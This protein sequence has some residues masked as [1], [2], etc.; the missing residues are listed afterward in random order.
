[1]T[2]TPDPPARL[3]IPALLAELTLEEKAA[4]LDGSDFWHTEPIARL[5]IPA[6]MVTDGPHGLRKQAVAGDHLGIGTSVPATCFPP[7][8]GLASTWDVDLLARVGVA[9]GDECRAE[10]VAVLLGPGV[11]M[12]RSPLCGRNFEYFS[13][14]PLLAGELGAALVRGIQSRGVGTSLKHFAA[15]NQETERMSVSAEVDERTL[16]EIYLP[17]FERIVTSARP[18]TVM[19]SYNRINGVYASENRWLLTDVLRGDWGY[20]GVVVSDWG[21]VNDRAAAVHAG[22]DLEMPSSGGGGQR[23]ILAAIAAGTLSLPDVDLAVTRVLTLVDRALPAL[24]PGQTFDAAA[25]HALAREAAAASAVLLK[26]DGAILPLDPRVGGAIAVVGEFARTPRYQG[27][28]SSQVVPTRLDDALTAVRQLVGG[29][30]E[31]T[32]APGYVPDAEQGDAALVAQAV[33]HA[34]AAQVVVLFLGLPAADE[35][36]GYDRTHLDLPAAQL[37][38]L[39]AVAAVNDQVVVVLSNGSVVALHPWQDRAR[40]VLEGW[41]LGQGGGQA[42]AD[43]LFGAVN[44]SGRLAETVPVRHCDNPTIGAF[45]G[46]LGSVRYGEGLLIGYRW[47]DAHRLEVSYP[48]GH[49][50]SYTTFGYT[51]LTTTVLCAGPE[52]QVEVGLTVTNTGSRAGRETVQVYVAD[53]ESSVFRPDQELKGFAPVSLEPG[54]SARVTLMLDARAFS[55][56][57][58]QLH[59]WVVEGG[60]FEIRVGASSRDVRLSGTVELTG[61]ALTPPLSPQSPASAWLDHPMTGPALQARFADAS[62]VAAGLFDPS[63]AEMMRAIPLDRLSRFPGFPIAEDELAA[64]ATAANE[65]TAS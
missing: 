29:A 19:C 17:A 64:L 62:N 49:G 59:R 18:W 30:R 10:Q 61:D 16:R 26:N 6:V 55:F 53:P 23:K 8:A 34:Q 7:A 12:K 15:N 46:E 44:P 35:S 47:Y 41:L 2:V 42:V 50:L 20:D 4:L 21:A 45:P 32:F 13:E 39:D 52:V 3:D 40:A 36:E 31:V 1:M 60:S 58:V 25:H 22:L 48:F 65:A 63:T 57:H 11:N 51:D 38:L 9:L 37:E 14:D 33:G 24:A 28:G 27:A 56:W 5:G 43:L 54:A